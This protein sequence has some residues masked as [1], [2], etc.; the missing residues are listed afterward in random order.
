[1]DYFSLGEKRHFQTA[2]MFQ[3][4]AYQNGEEL[5]LADDK[6]IDIRFGSKY[7]GDHYSFFIMDAES[8]EWQW[9]DLSETEIN[10]VKTQARDEMESKAPKLYMGDEYFVFNYQKFLDIYF[11]EDWDKI[12]KL[13]Q[14]KSIRSKLEA[15]NVKLL[16]YSLGG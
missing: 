3:V 13:S 9:I 8:G 14:D 11:N 2:G 1:M 7:P 6:N 4:Y 16:Q 15:Y 10:S 12:Y 5:K